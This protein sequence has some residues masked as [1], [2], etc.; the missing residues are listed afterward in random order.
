[1]VPHPYPQLCNGRWEKRG[2]SPDQH[3][4]KA[5][6]TSLT[7]EKDVYSYTEEESVSFFLMHQA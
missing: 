1:M 7:L 4:A 3:Q 2:T 5:F 6:I